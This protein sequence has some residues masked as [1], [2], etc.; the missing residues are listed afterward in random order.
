[1]IIIPWLYLSK[2]KNIYMY[3]FIK[4]LKIN[5]KYNFKTYIDNNIL[6]IFKTLIETIGLN[7][8]SN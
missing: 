4:N 3:K 8:I 6:H 7:I 1:M 5:T 2:T